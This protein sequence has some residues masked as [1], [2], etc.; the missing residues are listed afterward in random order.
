NECDFVIDDVEALIALGRLDKAVALLEPFE[1]VAVALD[2]P[3]ARG[4]CGRCRGLLLAA[5]GDLPGAL[6]ALVGAVE[7]HQRVSRP[8][9][10]ARTLLALG[11]MER[12]AK[13][14]AAARAPLAQA[15]AT[16][17]RVGA[18]L[19]VEK[20]QTELGRIGGRAPSRWELT[21]TEERVAAL[22]AVGHTNRE[23]AAEL[24]ISVR[25]VDWNLRKIYS[26]PGTPSRRELAARAHPQTG[27]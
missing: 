26:K 23:V 20:A 1:Q 4:R 22:V 19:W 3:T 27:S 10:P 18:R 24:V 9:Q 2:R 8:F 7:H 25:T 5:N 13:K 11:V 21:P 16:F 6:A 14:K 15:L 17:D 12:R